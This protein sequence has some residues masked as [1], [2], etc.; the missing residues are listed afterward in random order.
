LRIPLLAVR[1]DDDPLKR[2]LTVFPAR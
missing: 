2:L 1:T